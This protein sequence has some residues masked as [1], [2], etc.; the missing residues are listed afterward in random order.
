MKNKKQNTYLGVAKTTDKRNIVPKVKYAA[1]VCINGV[2]KSA[3]TYDKEEDAAVA[4]DN[5]MIANGELA[6]LN[7]PNSL[8]AIAAR[9]AAS[10]ST[11]T[12]AAA[13]PILAAE[14][15]TGAATTTGVLATGALTTGATIITG[16]TCATGATCAATTT[17]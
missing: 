2:R 7:F 13:L 9:V 14:S 6:K 5:E 10:H 16:D 15:A 1:R 12:A 11:C 3:G 17:E 8:Y 4:Y